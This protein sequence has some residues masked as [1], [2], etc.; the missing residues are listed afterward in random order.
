[1]ELSQSIY[2]GKGHGVDEMD[3][4]EHVKKSNKSVTKCV[5][6]TEK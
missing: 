4:N 1:M 3:H 5:K 6:D 2:T